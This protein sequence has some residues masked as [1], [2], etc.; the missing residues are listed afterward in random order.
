M[1]RHVA[2]SSKTS[3]LGKARRPT[4][5][6]VSAA[7]EASTKAV[8]TLGDGRGDGRLLAR[9]PLDERAR[10]LAAARRFI[11]V[12]GNDGGGIE[13]HL[14]KQRKA[15]DRSRRQ[16]KFWALSRLAHGSFLPANRRVLII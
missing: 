13:A 4:H 1:R 5:T 3:H 15:A 8:A 10:R 12:G 7:N 16:N 14:P 2:A 6:A 11:D 9:E